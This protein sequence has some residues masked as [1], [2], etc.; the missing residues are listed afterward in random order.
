MG[1]KTYT[2]LTCD[3]PDC[4]EEDG[5]IETCTIGI[6][7]KVKRPHLCKLHRLPVEQLLDTLPTPGRRP[8]R[9]PVTVIDPS[10]IPRQK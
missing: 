2:V 3:W 7:E 1:K 4:N 10:K 5:E 6:G 8:R 9:K